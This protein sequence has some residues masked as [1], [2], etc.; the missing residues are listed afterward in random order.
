MLLAGQPLQ[1]FPPPAPFEEAP[2]EGPAGRVLGGG[3]G[4]CNLR[5]RAMP[6][7]LTGLVKSRSGHRCRHASISRLAIPSRRYSS[8][9][10]MYLRYGLGAPLGRRLPLGG[11]GGARTQ[12]MPRGKPSPSWYSTI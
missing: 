10:R 4:G 2:A 11:A 1:L 7:L 3:R 8:A 6:A 12:A 5:Y 9:T